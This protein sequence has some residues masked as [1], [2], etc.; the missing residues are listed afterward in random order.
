[1]KLRGRLWKN[2]GAGFEKHL[3]QPQEEIVTASQSSYGLHL[4]ARHLLSTG[5]Q[6][7]AQVGAYLRFLSCTSYYLFRTTTWR[8]ELVPQKTHPGGTTAEFLRREIE[9]LQQEQQQEIDNAIYLGLTKEK[10]E[11]LDARR[12]L[13][14]ELCD[15]LY[16][17]DESSPQ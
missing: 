6:G 13:I 2:S 11:E 17:L 1:M 9:R 4:R 12:A 3:C 7:S 5:R 15:E 10:I 8:A 16:G 14:K